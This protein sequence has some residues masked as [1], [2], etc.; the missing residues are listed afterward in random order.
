MDRN[1]EAWLTNTVFEHA[2]AP[3]PI[4]Q[5]LYCCLGEAPARFSFLLP[6]YERALNP[7]AAQ[8]QTGTS[9]V[10]RS[11]LLSFKPRKG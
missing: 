6:Y 11:C 3:D 4:T 2:D 10:S 8:I 7:G 5:P 1:H 9:S